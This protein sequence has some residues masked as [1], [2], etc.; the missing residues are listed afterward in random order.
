MKLSAPRISTAMILALVVV[1]SAGCALVNKI[2]A[3]NELNETARSYREGQFD[4]A[5]Q[6][7]KRALEL[8]PDNPTAPIFVARVVHQQY[9]RNRDPK[10]G[11]EAIEAYRRV[12][13]KDPDSEEAYKAISVLYAELKDDQKLKE[14]IAARANNPNLKPEKRAEAYAVLAGKAWDC[15]FRITEAPD[16]KVI[17]TAGKAQVTYKKPKDPKDFEM[18]NKCVIEGLE[19]ANQAIK[20]DPTNETAW[21]YLRTLYV[22]QAKLAEMDGNAAL[23]AAAIKKAEDA[24]KREGALA[25]ERAKREAEAVKSATPSQ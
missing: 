11:Q 2:R 24:G 14:W 15:S 1:S 19:K 12:L 5:E 7:A 22:E 21:S 6:H 25:Q 16:V 20:L 10:K 17:T 3:K 8:D 23:K 9:E 4:Q 18:A 13:E